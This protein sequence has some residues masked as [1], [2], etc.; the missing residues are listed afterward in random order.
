MTTIARTF[1][2]ATARWYYIDGKPCYELAKKDGSGMKAPTL[3]DARKLNL[4]PSVTTILKV[5][6]KP[7]L[8]DWKVEQGVL[9][10]M[11]TPQ[12]PGE[13]TDEFIYRVLHVE[14]VQDQEGAAARDK[15][16]EIHAALEAYFQGQEYDPEW[17]PWILPAAEAIHAKGER[18]TTEKTLVGDGYAGRCDLI[19]ETTD[20]WLVWDFKSAKTLPDP[21]KGAWTEHKL[22]LAAYASAFQTAGIVKPI[23]TANCYI[24]TIE[25]GKFV[26]CENDPD[27][28][29]VY[30]QGF[31]PL[32]QYWSWLNSYR[33]QQ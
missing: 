3:A 23:R 10:V 7:A 20:A 30:N 19:Q 22:Q 16:T 11:T 13:S 6:D 2:E 1:S 18:V 27:W 14:R 12:K 32:V 5:L 17:A 8:N 15:G 26:I 33:A 29:K 25:Q 28:Q 31:K 24:S 4:V 9:A 21:K